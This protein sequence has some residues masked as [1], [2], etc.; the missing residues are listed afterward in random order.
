MNYIYVLSVIGVMA[1]CSYLPRVL[2]LVI[3]RK[4]I[5]NKYFYSFLVY[6]PYGVLSAMV[7]PDILYSTSSIYSAIGGGVSAIISSFLGLGLLPS[8]II[9]TIVTF[10]IERIIT[11]I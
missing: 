11:L 5:K 9:A 7:V 6:M 4:R 10:V 2:P 3:F 8:A 1:L